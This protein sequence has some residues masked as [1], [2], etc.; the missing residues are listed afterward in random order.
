MTR[1]VV[2]AVEKTRVQFPV[3]SSRSEVMHARAD[4]LH[5]LDNLTLTVTANLNAS[6]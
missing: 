5:H 2:P 6:D 4:H 1:Q 3:T